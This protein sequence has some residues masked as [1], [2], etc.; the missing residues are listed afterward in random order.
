M[1]FLIFGGVNYLFYQLWVSCQWFFGIMKYFKIN[2]LV[3]LV[4]K[5]NG[6]VF[7]FNDLYFYYMQAYGMIEILNFF[8]EFLLFEFFI[9]ID[10]IRVFFNLYDFVWEGKSRWVEVIV[11]VVGK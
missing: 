5:K 2:F 9:E 1:K 7:I 10:E 3:V 11:G 6:D 4:K 8:F